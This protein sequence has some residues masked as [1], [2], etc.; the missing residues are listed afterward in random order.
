[1]S[2]LEEFRRQ[3][4]E[5]FRRDPRSPL[6]PQQ[7]QRFRG[8]RYYPENPALRFRLP[9]DTNVEREAIEMETT[10]GGTQTFVRAGKVVF[11]VEGQEAT[12]YLYASGD[13][14]E[15]FL[16][17]RDLTSGKETYAAGRYLDLELEEDGTV[18]V[19]FNYAYNPY[20]A[21]NDRWTCPLP[22]LENWLRVPIR[23][24]ELAY[25]EGGAGH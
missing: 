2:E 5:F 4:N 6:T 14:R 18:L 24:G 21:Y 11:Q 22:P 20:C 19:D 8:L 1:M 15:L 23:A 16:P 25:E 10:T 12:L 17:F 9:L 13:A 3:K 7:R